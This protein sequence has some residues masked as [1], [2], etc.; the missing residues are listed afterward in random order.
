MKSLEKHK[1]TTS[2]MVLVSGLHRRS[3]VQMFS[4]SDFQTFSCCHCQG[5]ARGHGCRSVSESASA[6]VSVSVSVDVPLNTHVWMVPWTWRQTDV[7]SQT[8]FTNYLTRWW[9]LG[10]GSCSCTWCKGVRWQGGGS[11]FAAA[12][13]GQGLIWMCVVLVLTFSLTRAHQLYV[14]HISEL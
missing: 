14:V 11:H 1:I 10:R 9:L 5:H 3:H 8:V 12:R 4:C 7:S 13:C 2:P 6:S